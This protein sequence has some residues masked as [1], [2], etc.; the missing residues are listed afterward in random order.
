MRGVIRRT[1]KKAGL[2]A[3]SI[4]LASAALVGVAAT[5][6]ADD[7]D[8]QKNE[9]QQQI[10]QNNDE[11]SQS[12]TALDNATIALQQSN[13]DLASAQQALAAKQ[14][15]LA[16]AQAEDTRLAGE[17]T[18][19]EDNLATANTAVVRAQADVAA[20]QHD[21]AATVQA[22]N[23]QDPTLLSLSLLLT[24]ASGASLNNSV[25]WATTMFDTSQATLDRLQG[26]QADME[27]AQTQAQAAADDVTAKKAAAADHLAQTQ[28]LV[29]QAQA[30]E[31]AVNAQVASNT[32]AKQAAADA[33]A[34]NQADQKALDDDMNQILAQIQARIAAQKAAEEAAAKAAADKA[35]ADKAAADK[36]A[37]AKSSSSTSSSSGSSG[38]SN[39]SAPSSGTFFQPPVTGYRV[40]SPFG[41]RTDPISG[42]TAYHSGVDL[43]VPCGTP[44]HAAADGTVVSAGWYGTL[45]NYILIDNGKIDG[46]YWSTG[47]GHQ[48]SFAVSAGQH[49]T[50]GQVIG[51]VGTTGRSTGCHV[52]FN[53]IKNGTNINGLPLIT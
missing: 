49:V 45:G 18:T 42:V 28:D 7:L 43:A 47:Y 20:Q 2:G 14:A 3:L 21:I 22:S 40:T 30:A 13:A 53:A 44:I 50:R 46:N 25:Q 26:V 17:V 41:Y 1:C 23:Q 15:D 39:Q 32:Q 8:D 6:Q 29:T 51:Y 11:L 37:A 35:A 34:Q 27:Q 16:D 33:L 24:T 36:A 9:I 10:D 31:A 52:H 19:A 4:A 5:S 48:S 38:S 12:Q